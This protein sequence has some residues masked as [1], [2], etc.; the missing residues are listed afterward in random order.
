MGT[1]PLIITIDGPAAS[2]KTSVSRELARRLGWSWVSTGA[3]Y[4]GL[5]Y[6][7]QL[8]GVALDDENALSELCHSNIWEV[9]MTPENT[10]VF[11]KGKDI[12]ERIY[13]ED[14][15]AA[16]SKVSQYMKVRQNLLEVQRRCALN[17]AG[18]VAE[19]RD[20]GT[21]VFPDAPVKIYLDADSESRALRRASEQNKP[22]EE[23]KKAQS[24]RDLQ[25]KSRRAAPM[26]AAQDAHI[27][28]SSGMNLPEV[29]A[30]IN[31]IAR[32]ELEL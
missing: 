22:V 18:L 29:V 30:T 21:V 25:D 32:K 3:F 12:S 15:G 17:V 13:D 4:R 9:R 11:F 5:A 10:L 14:N 26:Q 1:K 16:A 6:V 24:L 2:G 23:T 8:A 20:C 31:N 7:A 28:D 19:G 27:I